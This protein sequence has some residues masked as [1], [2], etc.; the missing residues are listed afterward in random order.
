MSGTG[1]RSINSKAHHEKLLAQA[2]G[3]IRQQTIE[4]DRELKSFLRRGR[5]KKPLSPRANEQIS[6]PGV[7]FHKF[8]REYIETQKLKETP[9]SQDGGSSE[10]GQFSLQVSRRNEK[11]IPSEHTQATEP[12]PHHPTA[13]DLLKPLP[14]KRDVVT[15]TGRVIDIRLNAAGPLPAARCEP[16]TVTVTIGQIKRAFAIKSWIL[17]AA[18]GKCEC[19]KADAPF[20]GSD[21]FPYLE[22]HHVRPLADRGSDSVSNTVA[23][24]PNCHREIHHGERSNDLIRRLYETVPRLV[25][26]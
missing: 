25:R 12:R 17:T 6:K 16:E 5:S 19:C 3:A 2:R 1:G 13:P 15:R 20:T 9:A 24:C 8:P 21:G 26:E 14:K 7:P 18:K 4:T 10:I 22:V 11:E 23:M